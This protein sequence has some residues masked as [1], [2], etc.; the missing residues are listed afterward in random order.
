MK[1]AS[2]VIQRIRT[3]ETNWVRQKKSA[4]NKTI[5]GIKKLRHRGDEH[6]I[7]RKPRV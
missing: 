5:Q 3:T 4:K 2:K 1:Q 7:V 6:D